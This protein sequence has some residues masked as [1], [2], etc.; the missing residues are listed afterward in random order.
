MQGSGFEPR[1][2]QKNWYSLEGEALSSKKKEEKEG[3]ALQ[4]HWRN[5]GRWHSPIRDCHVAPCY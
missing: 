3:E 4:W 2:P 5:N 1:P